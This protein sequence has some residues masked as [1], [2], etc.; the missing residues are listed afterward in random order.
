MLSM[1]LLS[2]GINLLGFYH[3]CCSLVGYITHVLFSD[4]WCVSISRV[5]WG[6]LLGIFEVSVKMI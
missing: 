2:F 6:P 1:F 3:E 5:R 4:R